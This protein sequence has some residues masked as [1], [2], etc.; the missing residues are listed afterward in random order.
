MGKVVSAFAQ[1]HVMF[2]DKGVEEQA[3]NVFNGFKE[4]GE[5]LRQSKPDVIV[6]ISS[7]HMFNMM[8]DVQAPISVAV[9]DTHLPFGD[10]AIPVEP[11]KGQREFAEAFVRFAAEEGFDLTKYEEED[12]RPDHGVCIPTMFCNPLGDIPTVI[13]NLNINMDPIP[14]PQRSYALGE[15][16]RKYITEARP[17]GERIAVIGAGGI[18]HW[19]MIEGDGQ[20]NEEWDEEIIQTFA[21]GKAD[22]LLDLTVNDII[23]IGG[24]GGVEII[25]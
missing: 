6:I 10:L 24:N 7:D 15:V 13:I 20:I 4:I 14:S 9:G 16:L 11:F 18:S 8:S 1:S 3:A 23:K 22:T 21:Q 5:K 12:Y 2:N 17:E 19:L 25:S